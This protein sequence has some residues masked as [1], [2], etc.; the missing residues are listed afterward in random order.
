MYIYKSILFY[1]TINLINTIII[2]KYH[3]NNLK[4]NKYAAGGPGTDKPSVM[5]VGF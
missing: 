4:K 3:N 1:S 5:T 2:C